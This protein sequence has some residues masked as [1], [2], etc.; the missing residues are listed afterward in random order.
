MKTATLL[1]IASAVSLLF[2]A[3]HSIGGLQ[4]W[5]PTPD[6]PVLRTMAGARFD[7]PG[8]SRTWLDLYRGLGWS[9]SVYLLLQ[10]VLLWQMAT[11]AR[12]E[13]TGIRPMI[14]A[15]ALASLASLAV[16]ALYLF[17]IPA[18][19][20]AVLTAVLAVAW[21]SGRGTRSG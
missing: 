15:L 3:G 14:A 10:A 18:A 17:A 19:F 5:S 1:R 8:A 2:A 16:A 9:I 21:W 11:A 6:N 20:C 12:A 7:M 13:V 4:D